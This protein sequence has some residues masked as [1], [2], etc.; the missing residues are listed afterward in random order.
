M[1]GFLRGFEYFVPL[2]SNSISGFRNSPTLAVKHAKLL[3]RP[4][5]IPI[6]SVYKRSLLET[7]LLRFKQKKDLRGLEKHIEGVQ[8]QGKR[9]SKFEYQ[10]LLD[11]QIHLRPSYSSL[12]PALATLQEMSQLGY[13]PGE[14]TLG[15]LLKALSIRENDLQQ[16]IKR[17]TKKGHLSTEAEANW[18]QEDNLNTAWEILISTEKHFNYRQGVYDG[19]LRN[20]SHRGDTKRGAEILDKINDLPHLSPT[21]MTYASLIL[22]YGEAKDFSSSMKYFQEFRSHLKRFSNDQRNLQSVYSIAIV[23]CLENGEFEQAQ[24]ILEETMFDDDVIPDVLT[25]NSIIT[26]LVNHGKLIRQKSLQDYT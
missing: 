17:H 21:P 11:A 6:R 10:I 26:H 14:S 18:K 3:H 22:L 5:I 13:V 20:F 25:Y 12:K 24:R 15:S 4:N 16:V 23:S 1:S 8:N 2:F 7:Q 19:L 9:L